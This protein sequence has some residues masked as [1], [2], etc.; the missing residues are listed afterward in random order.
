MNERRYQV[1]IEKEASSGV[2]EAIGY[3][4]SGNWYWQVSLGYAV[5]DAGLAHSERGAERAASKVITAFEKSLKENVEKVYTVTP[6]NGRE[7]KW[8][9]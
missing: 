4:L 3:L 9:R 5:L 8:E 6:V 2:L 1:E 7:M